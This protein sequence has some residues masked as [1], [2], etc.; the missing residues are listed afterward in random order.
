MTCKEL[1]EWITDYMEERLSQSEI[2][3]VKQHLADCEGCETYLEQMRMTVR[4]LGTKPRVEIPSH[5]KSDLMKA[6]RS[7]SV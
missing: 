3:R 1:T 7:W 5:L 4:T 2:A 6:F